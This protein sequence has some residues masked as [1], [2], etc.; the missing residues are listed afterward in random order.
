MLAVSGNLGLC[1]VSSQA[2]LEKHVVLSL[3]VNS[4][5]SATSAL[6]EQQGL[7]NDLGIY[8]ILFIL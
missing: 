8:S 4:S 2:N 1:Y 3:Q 6:S 5:A 7:S